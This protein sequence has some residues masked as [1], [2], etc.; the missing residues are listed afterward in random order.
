[1][2]QSGPHNVFFS[3]IAGG[4]RSKWRLYVFSIYSLFEAKSKLWERLHFL[5][6]FCLEIHPEKEKEE[7]WLWWKKVIIKWRITTISYNLRMQ[8]FNYGGVDLCLSPCVVLEIIMNTCVFVV[9][10]PENIFAQ[11]SAIII[12]FVNTNPIPLHCVCNTILH[13]S[14]KHN[15]K[16][17]HILLHNWRWSQVNDPWIR[18]WK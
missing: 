8:V 12:I 3:L 13:F 10:F 5:A 18:I 2:A 16:Y 15:L 4:L 6:Y 9:F 11:N 17:I 14:P 7:L 1:M